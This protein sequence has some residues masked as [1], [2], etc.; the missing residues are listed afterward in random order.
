MFSEPSIWHEGELE[1]QKRAGVTSK[2]ERLQGM[3]RTSLPPAAQR[4]LSER[5]FAA[6]GSVDGLARVWASVV[7]GEPGF[8]QAPDPRTIEIVGGWAATDPLLENIAQNHDVGMLVMDFSTRRRM[9]ANGLAELGGD[10]VLRMKIEQAFSN[11]PR[12]IQARVAESDL[13]TGEPR[14]Q[15][16]EMLCDS[17]KQWIASADTFFIAT[18]HPSGG[19]DAS[20]KGGN[21][22]FIHVQGDRIL[23]I[24]DY[25][26]NSIFNTLGNIHVNPR[27]GL[28]FADFEAGRTLQLTGKVTI[29]W[30]RPDTEK[31][32]G[33]E[34]LLEFELEEALETENAF[35][36]RFRLE[37][38]SPYNPAVSK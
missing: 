20:H 33:A 21:P 12:Y 6:L 25:N 23:V 34:R 31:F 29:H 4:F 38:Y 1:A 8:L 18:A 19:V 16:S 14:Q 9:R 22:G 3:V 5:Q 32:P 37:S 15:R 27:A 26:G 10:G 35:P 11:C 24:P 7:V 30:E 13:R 36:L 28:V 17:E 2:A